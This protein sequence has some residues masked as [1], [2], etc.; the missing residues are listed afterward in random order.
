MKNVGLCLGLSV[1]VA[2]V[3]AALFFVRP[4]TPDATHVI[5]TAKTNG[6]QFFLTQTYRGLLEGHEVQMVVRDDG[7]AWKRYYVEHEDTYWRDGQLKIR[8]TKVE[9]RRGRSFIGDYDVQ[10]HLYSLQD[11]GVMS[12]I[13]ISQTPILT[14]QTGDTLAK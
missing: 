5:A 12:P 1:V 8:G 6:N 2:F 4:M 7:G 9:V 10:S 11:R 14:P 13:E 3:G